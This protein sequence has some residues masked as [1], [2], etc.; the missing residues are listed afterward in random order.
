MCSRVKKNAVNYFGLFLIVFTSYSFGQ[1]ISSDPAKEINDYCSDE[2]YSIKI[3]GNS[4]ICSGTT[5]SLEFSGTPHSI[6]AYSIN[7]E[8]R[9]TVILDKTGKKIIT[10]PILRKKTTYSLMS[11]ASVAVP[12]LIQPVSGKVTIEVIENP[13]A[14]FSERNPEH[15]LLIPLE[16]TP[17]SIVGYAIDG[18]FDTL[19]I[20]HTGTSVIT[21]VESTEDVNYSL[22]SSYTFSS[23]SCCSVLDDNYVVKG[24][25]LTVH[26]PELLPY[27]M[28]DL[29][30]LILIETDYL[31]ILPEDVKI[32]F[33]RK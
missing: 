3:S 7:D 23:P 31:A 27:Y 28:E 32:P 25:P 26:F 33:E 9:Q 24:Q 29:S 15:P 2:G 18:L 20:D 6:L 1:G 17:N 19:S 13:T 10:T 22:V 12:N 16:G 11:V 30:S 14:S 8:I 5:A 21:A 4:A